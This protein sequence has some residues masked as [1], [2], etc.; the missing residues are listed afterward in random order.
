VADIKT[1]N[2]VKD[3][4]VFDRAADVGT[5]MKNA[6][7]KSKDA[8]ESADRGAE[9]TQD[10]GHNSPSEYASDNISGAAWDTAQRAAN[11]LRKN[12]IKKASENINKAKDNMQEAK[13]QVNNIKNAVKKPATD[14]P[15]K[16]MVKR[17]QDTARRTASRTRGATDKTIKTVEKS[18]K[19]IKQSARSTERTIKTASKTVKGTAKTAQKGIKTAEKTAKVTVKTAQQTAKAT[20]RAAQAAAKAAKA[21][22]Q[23]SKAAAKVA[24]QAAKIAVKVTIATVKAIIAATKA[25]ISAIAAGGWVAVV[26]ILIICMIGLLVGS[27][28]GIFFSG[29]D[30]GNGYTMPMA[31][32]EINQEYADKI[33]EIRNNNSH[34]DV[35]MSGTRAEWKE[36][37]AVYAVK[38]NTDPDN[39]QDVA[40]MDTKK[41]ELLSSVFW[42]MSTVTHRTE[43]KEVTE[44]S[45]EG[46][47]NEDFTS[48]ET[49]VTKTILYIT[50]THKTA[51]EMAAQYGFSEQQK[52]Q[53]AE[54]LSDEYA[55]LWSA[56]LYGIHNGSGDIVAVAVSQ[57][58]N[59]NGE[60]YWSWYGFDSRVA[61]C[62]TFVS[63]CAN[64]C[65]Y[66]DAGIIPKF[67]AC[68]SQGIAWFTERGLY[69]D[70][71]YIPAPGDIIFFDWEPD[72][73]SD[74][75][76]I[77]E[78]VEGEVVHTVEGNTS[79]SVARRSY[80][81]DSNNICGYGTPMY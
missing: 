79:N 80:R 4:K 38:V 32:Q 7:V 2:T 74:H 25:L 47:D 21:A 16:E 33:A 75:V 35:V 55:D 8:V 67:A 48:T 52:A 11:S 60:P 22:A 20:Q 18:G 9:Q 65:G 76:G 44:V 61:W 43:T 45:V 57:I 78:Y 58:G 56:V 53:L 12:P 42:D 34:D 31:I 13:R 15:K 64:E 29:E 6:F 39:A 3:I 28:F 66:I 37:L 51:N 41:K 71:S 14:Q 68:Q 49:T 69:Q 77:V 27:V 63:W 54:L 81:L 26:I 70:S 5:H 40:T 24:I 17:A 62:A 46:D 50:V 30:G 10:T 73:H 23:A 59:V 19:T 72:G 1:K 36:I